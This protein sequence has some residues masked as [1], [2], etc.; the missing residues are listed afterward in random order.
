MSD[1]SDDDRELFRD[2]V[3]DVRRLK[4]GEPRVHDRPRPSAEPRQTEHSERSVRDE[5][6][7]HDIDP[8][9]FITGE[10]MSWLAPGLQTR[11]LKRLRRG[12]YS[13]GAEIDLHQMD[14]R[15]ARSAVDDFLAE[16]KRRDVRC[17]RII[18]GKGLRSPDGEPVLKRLVA[19][20]LVRRSDVVAFTS[21][22]PEDGGTGAVYA[23]LKGARS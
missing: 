8:D 6:L 14:V 21:A 9:A 17:V 15:T 19:G 13:I 1:I 10:E 20:L 22:R 16:S 4:K 11:V 23:L 7:T 5:L 3:E 12:H 18:H 2:A